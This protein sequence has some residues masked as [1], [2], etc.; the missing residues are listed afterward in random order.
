MDR[1]RKE[2]GT[3]FCRMCNYCQP[4]PQQ[5]MI[6]AIMYTRVAITRF[7]PKRIFEGEWN[8]FME[9][10]PD[11]ID[12]GECEERCPYNLPIRERIKEAADNYAAAKKVY[13]EKRGR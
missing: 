3:G 5:I 4:C 7:D 10:V 8:T 9:K 1:I 13:R 6:S 12:C 2:L 11:C